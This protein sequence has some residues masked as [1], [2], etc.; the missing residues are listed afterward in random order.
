MCSVLG[1]KGALLEADSLHNKDD[2][3]PLGPHDLVGK[4]DVGTIKMQP[5]MVDIQQNWVPWE[6][7]AK[8]WERS[9]KRMHLSWTLPS[10]KGVLH[11]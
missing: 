10:P 4:T 8:P 3:C 1:G 7:V 6:A 5:E 11:S 9:T 2:P